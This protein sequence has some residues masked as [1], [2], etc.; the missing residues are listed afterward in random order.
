MPTLNLAYIAEL[1]FK[2]IRKFAYI[3]FLLPFF[4]A[5]TAMWTSSVTAFLYFYNLVQTI[6]TDVSTGAGG[7]GDLLAKFFGL[8]NCIGVTDAY[9][10]TSAVFE[11]GL[12]FLF[13]SILFKMTLV[14]YK[15]YIDAIKT[16]VV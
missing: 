10:A 5:V 7:N 11:S 4:L 13:A 1:A 15:Y 3:A 12:I 14:S 8:L 16:L 9:T 2:Y 6:L